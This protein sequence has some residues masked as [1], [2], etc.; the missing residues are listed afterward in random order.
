[1]I[2]ALQYV[3]SK[4][5]MR[6]PSKYPRTL[7][8]G[9]WYSKTRDFVWKIRTETVNIIMLLQFQ[10]LYIAY[11][12]VKWGRLII[13]CTSVTFCTH[14]SF[15]IKRE[16]SALSIRQSN[17][18]KTRENTLDKMENTCVCENIGIIE[19]FGGSFTKSE[20]AP[21]I[22]TFICINCGNCTFV[23]LNGKFQKLEESFKDETKTKD[24]W[25]IAHN[26]ADLMKHK[27]LN[28]GVYRINEPPNRDAYECAFR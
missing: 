21:E 5:K 19:E 9:I 7:L 2:S 10:S 20:I 25:L 18:T 24:G 23:S 1:M 3:M 8:D 28:F 17:K 13:V 26:E 12:F 27:L 11:I 14:A 22:P 6:K 15:S 16:M 4:P